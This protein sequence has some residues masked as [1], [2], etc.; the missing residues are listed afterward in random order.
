LD[1]RDRAERIELV[2]QAMALRP[3]MP[4]LIQ[5][6]GLTRWLHGDHQGGLEDYS[7]ALEMTP[8]PARGSIYSSRGSMY[9]E[10][11][12]LRQ[13]VDDLSRAVE[14]LPDCSWVYLDRGKALAGLGDYEGA[15]ADF[16]ETYRLE[17]DDGEA[18]FQRGLAWEE[19][20]DWRSAVQDLEASLRLEDEDDWGPPAREALRA[21]RS[22]L[23][24]EGTDR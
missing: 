24:E 6:R 5:Q 16:T 1:C 11:G 20:G 13:A 14:I 3:G 10:L 12:R 2:T 8:E 4:G 23:A 19:L 7:A 9:L 18:L 22:R 15:I 17:S 21:A